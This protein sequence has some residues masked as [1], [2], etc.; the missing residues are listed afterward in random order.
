METGRVTLIDLPTFTDERGALTVMEKV[1]FDIKRAFWLHDLT[2][3]R[4]GHAHKDCHQLIVAMHRGILVKSD[5]ETWR[6]VGPCTGLYVPPGNNIEIFGP[7]AVV[8]V[9]CSHYFD[10]D[11]YVYPVR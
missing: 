8:L 3:W 9:L 2:G 4:G 5:T 11:D 10:K 1:P 6:L 7:G